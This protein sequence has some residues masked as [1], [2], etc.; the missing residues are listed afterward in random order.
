MK[1]SCIFGKINPVISLPQQ[2]SLFNPTPSFITG[3]YMTAVANPYSLGSNEVNFRVLYGNCTFDGQ[4]N[5]VE[6]K[7][8]HSDSVLLSG[9]VISTWGEDDSVI[10]EALA[11]QQGTNVV[12]I[13]FGTIS[14]G[15]MF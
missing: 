15:M 1:K 10:L 4:G 3:D 12:E 2:T 13:V 5:V 7:T 6:F 14:N 8:I 9:E 11:S